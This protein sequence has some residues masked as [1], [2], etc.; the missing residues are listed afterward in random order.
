MAC[1][2]LGNKLALLIY[3]LYMLFAGCRVIRSCWKE[4][5][6]INGHFWSWYIVDALLSYTLIRLMTASFQQGLRELP[7]LLPM[8]SF[9]SDESHCFVAQSVVAGYPVFVIYLLPCPTTQR[10]S[11]CEADM[12]LCCLRR[13]VCVREV[14]SHTNKCNMPRVVFLKPHLTA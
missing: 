12:H 4:F 10:F 2:P 1:F 3:F 14:E 13:C 8:A 9:C 6:W 7:P 11:S 5:A